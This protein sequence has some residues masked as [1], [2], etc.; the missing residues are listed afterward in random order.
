M[1]DYSKPLRLFALIAMSP[2]CDIWT[3]RAEPKRLAI[4]VSVEPKIDHRQ[5]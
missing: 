2:P 3:Q 1:S 5:W 4:L